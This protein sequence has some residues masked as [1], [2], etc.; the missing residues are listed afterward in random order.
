LKRGNVDL[1]MAKIQVRKPINIRLVYNYMKVL[2]NKNPALSMA[3]QE[4]NLYPSAWADQRKK[5]R[6]YGS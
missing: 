6:V 5:H 1:V 2:L 3:M 4:L